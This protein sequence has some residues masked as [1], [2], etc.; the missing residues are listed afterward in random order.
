MLRDLYNSDNSWA[1]AI[2]RYFNPVGAHESGL[3]GEDPKG[4]PSN[5]MPIIAQSRNWTT[6]KAE[7]LGA[8]T[9]R[10][11]MAPAYAHYIHVNDLAA[12]HLK[13]LKKLDKPKCFA[14]NLGTG[15]GYSVL[16]VIKAFEHV[17]N[18]E[19]KYEIAPRRPGDVAECYA[20]PGFARN[21]WAGR[22]RKTCV[23]CVRT[24][25]TGNRKIRTATNKHRC[26]SGLS[27]QP[28]MARR[29]FPGIS[30]LPENA[31]TGAMTSACKIGL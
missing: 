5:L 18:R 3:I 2:L 15:Q 21:F 10:H 7:H 28:F 1:I 6:R 4:I 14:V 11:R 16:D 12:G 22:L 13:A 29:E 19:I 20:D 30:D 17:S 8:T 27:F 24:C 23:K 25:G 31:G 26:R 9:I